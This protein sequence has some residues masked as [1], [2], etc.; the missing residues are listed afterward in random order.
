MRH[1]RTFAT[2]A[3]VLCSLAA[4]AGFAPAQLRD[5]PQDQLTLQHGTSRIELQIWVADTDARQSQGLMF[6]TEL[7]QGYGMLFPL[8]EPR[9][10]NMWMKNTYVPLDMVFV[11]IDGAVL[12]IAADTVPQSTDIISSGAVVGGVLEIR[13]GESKRLGLKVG[14]RVL[15]RHFGN[16]NR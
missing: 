7:P 15:H 6:L 8:T 16:T 4:A 10:M 5:F 9:V 11:G 14:D 1:T 13:A 3:L 2:L 12:R